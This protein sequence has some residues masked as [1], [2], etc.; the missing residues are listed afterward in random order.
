MEKR[1]GKKRERE[2]E[3]KASQAHT[4]GQK[5]QAT[6][7]QTADGQAGQ[8]KWESAKSA[9]DPAPIVRPVVGKGLAGL[10]GWDRGAHMSRM[11]W[12][13]RTPCASRF[14]RIASRSWGAM[15]RSLMI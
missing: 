12:T 15:P 10:G 4:L 11:R 14:N 7:K 3:G 1:G 2:E 8:G 5:G 13:S 6:H 9:R